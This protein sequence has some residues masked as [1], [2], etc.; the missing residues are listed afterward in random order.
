MTNVDPTVKLIDLTDGENASAEAEPAPILLSAPDVGERERKALLDAFDSGWIAPVGPQLDQFEEDLR[1]YTNAE[2]CVAV[3]S[4]TA[5]LHLALLIAGVKPGNEVVV[6]S[7]TFAAS[8]FAV[9]HAGAVPV[10]CDSEASSWCMDPDVLESFLEQ[11]A[12][13]DALP[14]AVMPVD[15][16]GSTA[17]Y[18]ELGRVCDRF[19][20]P[21]VRDAAEA[22]GSRSDTGAVG[23]LPYPSVLSFNGNKI[24]TT[25]SGGALVGDAETVDRARYLA[26]QAR[27][28]ALH[29]EHIDVG[30]NYR[31]SNLLAALG[32]AQLAGLEEKIERRSKTAAFYR[33]ALPQLEWC[34]YAHTPRPNNWLTVGLLPPGADP[35]SICEELAAKGI[36][37]RPA[38]KPMHQQPVFA[39]NEYIS[40][41]GTADLLFERGICLASG[42]SLSPAE[43]DRVVTELRAQLDPARTH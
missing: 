33:A 2:A 15:L 21:L 19:G 20:V 14:A 38:W 23:E 6:Q 42:S 32:S 4:G 35:L 24:I 28:P 9:V 31:M 26:T 30:Y 41:D 40:G 27:Q 22:L 8:A 34:N 25:S 12:S 39:A 13:I 10:F 18:R 17:N 1:V 7:A 16:F 36:G 11:R 5:A 3:S 37:A 29:Y 43:I